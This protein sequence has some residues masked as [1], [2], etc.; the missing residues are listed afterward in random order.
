ATL[1]A[2]SRFWKKPAQH[3][4]VAEAICYDGTPSHSERHWAERQ[5][6]R[7]REFTVTWEAAV[8]LLEHQIPFTLTTSEITSG[9]LQAVVGYD[10]L[11]QTLWIRDPFHYCASEFIFKALAERYRATGP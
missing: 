1:S 11:R 2:I 5:G 8:A 6:W 7:A 4:E 10:E 9:H 3:L